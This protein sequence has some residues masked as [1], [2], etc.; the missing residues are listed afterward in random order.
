MK[1]SLKT[2][3][4]CKKP[5]PIWKRHKGERFCQQCW[6][7]HPD[8]VKQ[9]PTVKQKPIPYRSEKRTKEERIYAAERIIFLQE[10]PLCQFHIPGI[11]TKKS[12]EV[13]HME[14]RTGDNYLDKTK[15]K[16]GCHECH[17]WATNNP[18]EAIQLGFSLKRIN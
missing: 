3:A 5:K 11:C 10:H 1:P 8:N 7:C 15:W 17:D 4:G 18:E 14:G 6:S 2:C 12:T 9:K 13:H 16:A